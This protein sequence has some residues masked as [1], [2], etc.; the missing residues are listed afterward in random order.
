MKEKTI[1]RI[2]YEEYENGDIK[3]SNLEDYM[4][5]S[6]VWALYG[7]SR[8]TSEC[9]CLNV[10]KSVNIGN[11]ILYDIA[12]MHY[13]KLREGGSKEYMNQFGETCGFRYETNQV[14]EYLYPYIATHWHSLKYIYIHDTSN[15]DI[16]SAFARK[17]KA[18]YWRNGGPFGVKKNTNLT[19]KRM[20]I[21]G[22]LFLD[23]GEVYTKNE[24]I[25]VIE[26]ELGYD[27]RKSSRLI[28]DCLSVGFLIQ[29]D[30][31]SYTR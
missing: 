16:E 23:G 7:N 6:G 29:M 9:S 27:A 4:L 2:I 22:D 10:G 26:K 5:V 14:Q 20:Q 24:L 13:L 11:K 12:C 25:Q 18:I 17:N 30:D 19:S 1:E 21:I 3:E 15:K 8:E 31:D 28:N